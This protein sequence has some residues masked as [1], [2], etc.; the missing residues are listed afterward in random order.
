MIPDNG[1]WHLLIGGSG[2]IRAPDLPRMKR[3]HW[4]HYATLPYFSS[5]APQLQSCGGV[6]GWI[7]RA[8]VAT[9]AN[10]K[11]IENNKCMISP[12]LHILYQKYQESACTCGNIDITGSR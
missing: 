12:C 1:S 11:K 10:N 7:S 3:L 4:T 6:I 5:H 9:V 8:D 2:G